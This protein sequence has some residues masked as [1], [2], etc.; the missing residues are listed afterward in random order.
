MHAT[1][2]VVKP[3]RA[4]DAT[5]DEMVGL[6]RAGDAVARDY[7]ID[8]HYASLARYLT[9]LTYD[10]E[11]AADL[12]QDA[13]LKA[14]Q[15]F[16][17][18]KNDAAFAAWL[19]RIARNEWYS[20]LRHRRIRRVVSLDWLQR[21]GDGSVARAPVDPLESHAERQDVRA[22]MAAL[23]A[24]DQEVLVLRHL[25]GFGGREIGGI[26]G[27]SADAAQRRL[28]RAE[29]RFRGCYRGWDARR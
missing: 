28:N 20:Q 27:I 8:T 10:P 5:D 29:E 7:L 16:D 25:A 15:R 13:F 14:F 21:R 9:Q 4:H 22:A 2:A 11:Q 18:L 24:A 26:L 6:A 19:Y 12:T 23:S 3:A 17:Q 1:Q